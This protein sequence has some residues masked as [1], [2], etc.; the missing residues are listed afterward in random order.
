MKSSDKMLVGIVVGILLLVVVAL[1]ATLSRS[2][3]EYLPAEDP[4]AT[5]HNYLLA[6]EKGDF[7]RA[8]RYISPSLTCYPSSLSDFTADVRRNSWAFGRD[9]EARSWA[10]ED[11]IVLGDEATVGVAET[12]FRDRGLFESNQSFSRFSVTLVL[13][14]DEW[15]IMDSDR[16]FARSDWSYSYCK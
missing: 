5:V 13:E 10:I 16:F 12:R 14:D 1:V 11:A 6:L 3:V 9:G 4:G 7:E 15:R 8:Y 2:P